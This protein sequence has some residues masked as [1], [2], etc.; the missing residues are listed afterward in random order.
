[1]LVVEVDAVD[2]EPGR[3]ARLPSHAARTYAGSPR[4]SCLPSAGEMP[5]L[6][7]SSTFSLT[8]PC[9]A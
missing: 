6:V 1:V 7:A 4:I 3:R 9:K 8:P 2:A 5:N